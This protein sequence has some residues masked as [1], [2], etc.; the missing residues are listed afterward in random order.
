VEDWYA[1]V[2]VRDYLGDLSVDGRL[3]FNWIIKKEV[4]RAW[5][6]LAWLRTT[7][8]WGSSD[9]I[10]FRINRIRVISSLPSELITFQE[11]ICSLHS[12]EYNY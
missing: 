9:N 12:D 8:N 5:I 7:A 2:K 1:N 10:K 11:D 3:K 4:G 6:E